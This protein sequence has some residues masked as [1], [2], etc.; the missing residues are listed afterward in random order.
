MVVVANAPELIVAVDTDIFL[1]G[2]VGRGDLTQI[3]IEARR[4]ILIILGLG[5]KMKHIQNISKYSFI[6]Y[7]SI[8][9]T[10]KYKSAT[11]HVNQLDPYL[12][13]TSPIPLGPARQT[14]TPRCF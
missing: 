3:Q 14:L 2:R 5:R 12:K 8:H 4:L 1:E 6:L 9:N 13:A 10:P 11:S 7:F